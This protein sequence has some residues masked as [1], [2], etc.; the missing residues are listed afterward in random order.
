MEYG[1]QLFSLR[2]Y[3]RT[4]GGPEPTLEMLEYLNDN[5]NDLPVDYREMFDNVM[6]GFW[7]ALINIDPD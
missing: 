5:R 7:G 3:V 6:D 1:E 2:K 4:I